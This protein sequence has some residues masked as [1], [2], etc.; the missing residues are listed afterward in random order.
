MRRRE[1][2]TLL[3]GVAVA[4]PLAVPAARSAG[5]GSPPKIGWLKI[6][7]PSH[8]PGQLMAFREGMGAFGLIE[9]RD[10]VLVER[11]GDGKE[12]RLPGP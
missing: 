7:G 5:S 1:F 12:A 4:G 3:G 2:I 10:H 9:G 11:Y 6:Q 8:T